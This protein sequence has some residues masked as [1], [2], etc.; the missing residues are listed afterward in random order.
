MILWNING[1]SLIKEI[2]LEQL[3]LSEGGKII[4]DE[5]NSFGARITLEENGIKT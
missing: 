3:A 5:E 2:R 1:F 4:R